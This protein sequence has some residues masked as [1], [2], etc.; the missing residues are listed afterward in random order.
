MKNL[1]QIF[2]FAIMLV[3]FSA[4]KGINEKLAIAPKSMAGKTLHID[5]ATIDFSSNNSATISNYIGTASRSSVSYK[6][7]SEVTADL[8]FSFY[9]EDNKSMSER[10][11]D[12]KLEFA[13]ETQGI[14]SGSYTY[15]LTIHKGTKYERNDSGTNTLKNSIF[16]IY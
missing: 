4:C 8:S 14:A 10:S 5:G 16:S 7:T 6:R 9:V 13:D 15:R 12:L 1:F 2:V 3:S 11:Y